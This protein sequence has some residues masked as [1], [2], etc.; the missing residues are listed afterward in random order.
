MV[1]FRTEV[2]TILLLHVAVKE[3]YCSTGNHSNELVALRMISELREIA[4]RLKGV[5]SILVTYGGH[6]AHQ[7]SQFEHSPSRYSTIGA[8]PPM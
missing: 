7:K 6:P 8:P 2:E 4:R 3:Q 5:R 1:Y